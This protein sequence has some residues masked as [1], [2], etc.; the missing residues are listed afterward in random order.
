[1]KFR[2]FVIQVTVTAIGFLV[3]F[4]FKPSSAI[5]QLMPMP[6]QPSLEPTYK[7]SN[8]F[9]VV[10]ESEEP[11]LLVGYFVAREGET[12][13]RFE[14]QTAPRTIPVNP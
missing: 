10:V 5:S 1:M 3:L 6:P 2:R 13:M 4:F 8:D 7:I 9:G 12:W 14:V 11:N